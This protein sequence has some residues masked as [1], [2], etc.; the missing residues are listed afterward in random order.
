MFLV[1][2]LWP[3]TNRRS[4]GPLWRL[5]RGRLVFRPRT[6]RAGFGADVI[7]RRRRHA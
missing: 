2:A 6:G 7:A 3:A 1:S 5:I 4:A